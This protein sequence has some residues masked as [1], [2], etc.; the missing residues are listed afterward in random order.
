MPPALGAWARVAPE[1]SRS[2]TVPVAFSGVMATV[3]VAGVWIGEIGLR[4]SERDG[5]GDGRDCNGG[6]RGGG[7]LVGEVSGVSGG[8]HVRAHRERGNRECGRAG[9]EGALSERLFCWQGLVGRGVRVEEGYRTRGRGRQ[10][11]GEQA[12]GDTERLS[13][14]QRGKGQ[15]GGAGADGD[16]EHGAARYAVVGVAAV[17]SGEGVGAERERSGAEDGLPGGDGELDEGGV[18][19]EKG[20]GAGGRGRRE[21]GGQRDEATRDRGGGRGGEGERGV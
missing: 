8:E 14:G 19:V 16:G 17:E 2:R 15:G 9:G 18:A 13:R 21:V 5:G 6:D 7:R 11:G 4:R 10:D 3:K 20:N 12:G 1:L